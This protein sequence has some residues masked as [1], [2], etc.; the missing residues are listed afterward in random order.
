MSREIRFYGASDD[1]FECEDPG[2]RFTEEIGCYNSAAC[3]VIEDF[4]NTGMQVVGLYAPDCLE[5]GC[6]TVGIA[7]LAEDAELPDWPVRY[8][9]SKLGYSPVLIL[10]VPDTAKIRVSKKHAGYD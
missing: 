5:D 7:Q 3:Y 9:M 1:L 8:E 2:G 10:T 6:W 4:G